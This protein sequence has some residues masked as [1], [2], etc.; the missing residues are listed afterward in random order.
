MEPLKVRHVEVDIYTNEQAKKMLL[1]VQNTSLEIPVKLGLYL[2]LRR[3]EINGL[4]WKNVDL[5]KRNYI[6]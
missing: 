2:G 1:L 3:G 5:Q 6:F 4:K